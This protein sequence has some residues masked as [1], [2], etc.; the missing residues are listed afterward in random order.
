MTNIQEVHGREQ[1]QGKMRAQVVYV[2]L[3]EGAGC[4]MSSALRP[5]HVLQQVWRELSKYL[6]TPEHPHALHVLLLRAA[7]AGWDTAK[8]VCCL[9]LR[10]Y[11]H[12]PAP[13][14]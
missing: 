6:L 12:R 10:L 7:F 8:Q 1:I 13:A 4:G 11:A 14:Q 3:L 9:A 2:R 5:G